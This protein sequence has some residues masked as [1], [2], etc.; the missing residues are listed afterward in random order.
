MEKRRW[1][2]GKLAEFFPDN[3]GLLGLNVNRGQ[4]I[5]IRL[6]HAHRWV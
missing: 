5:L 6:R 1:R 2:V 3:G 4:K